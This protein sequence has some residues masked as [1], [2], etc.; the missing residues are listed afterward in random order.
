MSLLLMVMTSIRNDAN[1]TDNE[2]YSAPQENTT[3]QKPRFPDERR[4]KSKRARI[5]KGRKRNKKSQTLEAK[6]NM[7]YIETTFKNGGNETNLFFFFLR[8]RLRRGFEVWEATNNF[9]CF[10]CSTFPVT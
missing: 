5:L 7:E 6:K 8:L 3:F 10:P 4:K 9:Q 1:E 2:D